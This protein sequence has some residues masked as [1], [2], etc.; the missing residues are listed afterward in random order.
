MNKNEDSV[1]S[2]Q[3]PD[4][5]YLNSDEKLGCILIGCYYANN[6][7][8]GEFK[9]V[10]NEMGMQLKV[11]DEAWEVLCK[12]PELIELM[13]RICREKRKYTVSEFADELIKLGYKCMV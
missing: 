4:E 11:Y 12:M 8:D 5:E 7:T 3:I 2:F 6:T 13:A 10:W 1:K 9:I